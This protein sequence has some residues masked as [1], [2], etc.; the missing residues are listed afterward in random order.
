M[1]DTIRSVVPASYGDFPPEP[2]PSD[3]HDCFCD[4]C[5]ECIPG[6]R[7]YKPHECEHC[8]HRMEFADQQ[9]GCTSLSNRIP[10]F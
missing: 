1:S 4:G 2:E 6:W 10:R 7:D 3:D 9:C 8:G 5:E